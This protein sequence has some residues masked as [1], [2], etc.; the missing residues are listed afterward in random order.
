MRCSVPR[1]EHKFLIP[2]ARLAGLRTM[3]LPHVIVDPYAADRPGN[4]YTV[5]SLYF[6]TDRLDFYQEK[7]AGLQERMKIRI[8]GY[9]ELSP[10]RPVY[11]E[12]K[13]KVGLSI[14]KRRSRILY[15]DIN[16][17]LE[18]HDIDRYIRPNSHPEEMKQNALQF[19]FHIQRRSLGPVITIAY[20]REPFLSRHDGTL[21][22]TVDKNLRSS[23]TS[24]LR[25]AYP[26]AD[27]VQAMRG[28]VILEIKSDYAFPLWLRL[29]LSRMDVTRE[30]LS[31]YVQC[32][33]SLNAGRYSCEPTH[34]WTMRDRCVSIQTP[35]C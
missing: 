16:A 26:C 3:I 25:L 31:K 8:R 24:A 33:D 21:R 5:H 22:I 6:D 9:N 7:L 18:T 1:Q 15:R 28:N 17:I 13:R 23:V 35:P 2:E 20:E 27:Y 32:I 11:L 30:A 14:F 34:R 12:I 29:I 19:L 10:T 4:E